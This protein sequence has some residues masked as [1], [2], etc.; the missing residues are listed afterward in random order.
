MDKKKVAVKWKYLNKNTSIMQIP[1]VELM[2]ALKLVMNTQY[3]D[4]LKSDEDYDPKMLF[5]VSDLQLNFK[6]QPRVIE[7]TEKRKQ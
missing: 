2:Q 7:F 5:T 3:E 1:M 4:W 6:K